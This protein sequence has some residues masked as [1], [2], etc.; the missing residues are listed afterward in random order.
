MPTCS[1]L[2]V[3]AVDAGNL[4]PKRQRFVKQYKTE[5]NVFMVK[6]FFFSQEVHCTKEREPY[7]RS[8]WG[9]STIFTTFSNSR[10]GVAI[11]FS[12]NFQFQILKYFADPEGRFVIADRHRGQNYDTSKCLRA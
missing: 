1:P 8:E 6:E 4:L 9:Y 10:A 2:H 3:Q 5:R 11:L 12:N 7:W